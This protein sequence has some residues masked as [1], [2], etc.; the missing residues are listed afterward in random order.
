MK[1]HDTHSACH[2]GEFTG[3]AALIVVALG[4]NQQAQ[5][6]LL[7]S[8]CSGRRECVEC[9]RAVEPSTAVRVGVRLLADRG[10]QASSL[11]AVSADCTRCPAIIDVVI[12]RLSQH[13]G[14]P[15][16]V[17]T[18]HGAPTTSRGRWTVSGYPLGPFATIARTT[19]TFQ[20]TGR[21]TVGVVRTKWWRAARSRRTDME[22]ITTTYTVT[23]MTCG[24]CVAAVS[25][26]VGQIDGV[27]SVEVEL[28]PEGTSLVKVSGSVP[29]DGDAVGAAVDE[30]GYVVTGVLA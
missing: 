23:G 8:R 12:V 18:A 29:A 14:L 13:S 1:R 6:A 26:E 28:V 25:T 5:A 19:L 22:T 17:I 9:Q 24:H 7:W 21:F 30:A 11:G 2:R 16:T 3:F 4:V 20:W 27:T 10:R 15:V